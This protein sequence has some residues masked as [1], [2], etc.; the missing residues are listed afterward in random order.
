MLRNGR[1]RILFATISHRVGGRWRVSLNVEAQPLHPMRRHDP[2]VVHEPVGID[3][4]LATFAV[5]A[6]TRAREIERIDSPRPLRHALPKL[7]RRSREL[8]RKQRGSRNR[9]RARE[10]LSN[11]HRRIKD[12]RHDFVHR[13]SSRLAKSHGH[14]VIEQLCT[15]G[16]MRSRH[17]ARAI[18]DSAWALFATLLTYKVAWYGG[19]LTTADRFY[20]STRCCSACRRV[21]DKLALSERVFRCSACGHEAD[22][23]TNAAACLAQYPAALASGS[24]PLVA[25]KHA[26]TQNVCGEGSSGAQSLLTVRET[27]FD[28]AERALAHHPRRVVSTETVN[29]L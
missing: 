17:F 29:T 16:L 24:W 21:G 9:R 20:P 26:E 19:V 2:N 6:D 1:A 22:R 8:S 3:R 23:D 18:A 15:L 7:R 11:T 25:A 14:L 10:R 4:G 27:T 5:V 12:I 28:E 13:Q